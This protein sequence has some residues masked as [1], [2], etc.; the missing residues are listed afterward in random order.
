MS[1]NY[2]DLG[3]AQ[4]EIEAEGYREDVRAERIER[5]ESRN[6]ER[7][8]TPRGQYVAR[9]H[10]GD[11]VTFLAGI[12]EVAF[13]HQAERFATPDAA[14]DAGFLFVIRNPGTTHDVLDTEG[15]I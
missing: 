10:R 13:E 11:A 15:R 9:I 8:P 5:M 6:R 1:R 14:L 7:L 3:G 12:S 4:E 2:F